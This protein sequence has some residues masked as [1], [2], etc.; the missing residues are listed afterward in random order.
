M[1]YCREKKGNYYA[2]FYDPSRQPERKW[3]TLR[4]SDKQNARQKLAELERKYA[5]DVYDPW[6]EE[7]PQEGLTVQEAIDQFLSDYS[8]EKGLREKTID[9]YRY[10]LKAFADS[11]A[12]QLNIRYVDASNIRDYLDRDDLSATSRDT[13]YRQLKT[14]FG[15]CDEKN[16]VEN[17]P[18]GNVERPGAPDLSAKFLTPDQLDDLIETIRKAAE[19]NAPHVGEGEIL[20]IIDVIKFAVYTGL[21][22]G[23]LCNLRWGAIDLG[24]G[25]LTVKN[26]EDFE[27]KTGSEGRVPIIPS[28]EEIL[29]DQHPDPPNADPT[30]Y[31][32]KGVK[33]GQLNA[34][35][36]T[37]RFRYYR[38]LAGLPE[39]ISF[40]SLRD[41][42]AC[43][44]LM[45]GTSIY[46]VKEM[47]RH[48]RIEVTMG[49]ARLLPSRFKDQIEEGMEGVAL[50][51]DD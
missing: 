36:V 1:A 46:T 7:S 2:V 23:E 6:K 26:T 47:L 11:V 39:G 18:I 27:T 15:W 3:R 20:W 31:V 35:Y 16:I 8:E 13:Y 49:Y 14:F 17:D 43:L 22:R 33:G 44:L 50:H 9:N 5:L 45:Q 21:R 51:L 42:C 30:E 10:T 24:T 28:A 32:F 29:E 19:K 40:H 34:D 41:T 38:R 4:T 37:E 12:V 25:F 48:S